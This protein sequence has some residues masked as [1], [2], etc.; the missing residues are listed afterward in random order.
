MVL[1]YVKIHMK[2]IGKTIVVHNLKR[3]PHLLSLAKDVKF[4]KYTVP[5]GNW[6]PSSRMAVHYVTAVLR[7]LHSNLWH[8]DFWILKDFL[9]LGQKLAK[10]EMLVECSLKNKHKLGK[11]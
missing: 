5:T 8:V 6:T 9:S 10:S 2:H 4:D 11:F 3:H 7:K 1:Y